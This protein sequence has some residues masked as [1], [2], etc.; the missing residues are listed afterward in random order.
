VIERVTVGHDK[1]GIARLVAVLGGG[2]VIGVGI[3]RGDGSLVTALLTAGLPVF[4]IRRRR[5]GICVAGTAQ[6]VTKTTVSMR[7]S[8]LM[9]C[10]PTGDG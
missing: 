2:A 10:A 7:S 4:V 6:R 1:A 5:S 8:W 9:W 3:E